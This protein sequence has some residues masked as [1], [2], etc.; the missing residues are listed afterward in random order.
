MI[1]LYAYIDP[2]CTKKYRIKIGEARTKEEAVAFYEGYV[3]GIFDAK[4]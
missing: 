3:K 1:N 4:A 2:S